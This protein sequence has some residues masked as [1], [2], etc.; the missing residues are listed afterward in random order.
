MTG[1]PVNEIPTALG[2][3]DALFPNSWVVQNGPSQ[4]VIVKLVPWAFRGI[5]AF[6][7]L[8][9]YGV[10]EYSKIGSYTD[11]TAAD[12]SAERNEPVSLPLRKSLEK[13]A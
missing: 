7:R 12:L 9:R 11:Y 13:A 4:C 10:E 5:G 6:H 8:F 1:V 3:F 2:A